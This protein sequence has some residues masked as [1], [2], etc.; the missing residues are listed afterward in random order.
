[1][2]SVNQGKYDEA[3]KA[4]EEAIRLDPERRNGLEQQRH[5]SEALGK[6]TEAYAAFAKAKV[7]R[8][9]G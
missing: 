4:F 7:L 5:C 2:L 9:T 1:M 3:I 6:T 8:Y